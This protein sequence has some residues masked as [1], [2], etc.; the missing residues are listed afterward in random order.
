MKPLVVVE[1]NGEMSA[2]TEEQAVRRVH[3]SECDVINY[4]GPALTMIWGVGNRSLA[5]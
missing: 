4:D 1:E 3:A 2:A 5:A